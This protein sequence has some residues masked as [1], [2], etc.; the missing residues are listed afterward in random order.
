MISLKIKGTYLVILLNTC[1]IYLPLNL[2]HTFPTYKNINAVFN[3]FKITV[4]IESDSPA[5]PHIQ[6]K[7]RV[8]ILLPNIRQYVKSIS[9]NPAKISTK[10]FAYPIISI[11][12][13]RPIFIFKKLH[14]FFQKYKALIFS[15]HHAP[16]L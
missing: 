7:Y 10:S 11:L 8:L 12:L 3:I 15:S 4:A 6:C 1:I 9:R 2:S 5:A 14:V 16:F 13:S